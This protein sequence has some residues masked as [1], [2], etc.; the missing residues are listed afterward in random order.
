MTAAANRLPIGDRM[1]SNACRHR[2]SRGFTYLGLIILVAIIGLVCATSL[3]MGA[4]LQRHATEQELLDIGAEFSD[5]LASYAGATPPGQPKAPP[6]LRDLLKDPR[7]PNP[8]RHLRKLYVDPI[9]G[10]AEWGLMYAGGNGG[11]GGNGGIIGVYSMS[12]GQPIKISNFARRFE[13]FEGKTHLSDWKFTM[14]VSPASIPSVPVQ[15]ASQ[16]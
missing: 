3:K 8:R 12:D 1:R 16:K 13:Q 7:F 15:G 10:K 4:L 9:T 6:S 14:P 11:N 2:H 5:A